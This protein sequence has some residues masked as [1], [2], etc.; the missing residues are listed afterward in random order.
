MTAFPACHDLWLTTLQ[1]PPNAGT[2]ISCMLPAG[3]RCAKPDVHHM[4]AKPATRLFVAADLRLGC[5]CNLPTAR[6][7][8]AVWWAL[9]DQ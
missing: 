9:P 7:I 6:R 2:G 5:R 4:T 8:D 3:D 1:I